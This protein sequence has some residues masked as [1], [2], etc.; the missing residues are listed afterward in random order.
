MSLIRTRTET[1]E[2]Y[3]RAAQ[4]GWTLPCICTENLTTTEA[5]LTAAEDF[6]RDNG[7]STL[8]VIVAMTCRYPHRSQAANYTHTRRWETGLRLFTESVK[9]LAGTGGP[10][11][12]LEVMLHLDH[13]QHDL[14][15]ELLD[16]DLSDYASIMFDAS[17]LPFDENIRSTAAFI[18]RRG[19][20]LLV[21]GACDEIVDATGGAH[22][23][24]TT[25]ANARRFLDE[26]GAD[27]IV[28]NLGTEHRASG[29]ELQYHGEL[30]REIKAV[31]GERIVLHG[32]S[33]V[34]QDQVA[35]LFDD[36]VC[37]VNIWTALERDS[38]PV[39][40]E[41]M[42]RNAGRIAGRAVIDRLI[43]DGL[44]APTVPS[45]SPVSLDRFTTLY[46]QDIVF[47]CMRRLVRG[48]YD[49]WYRL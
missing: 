40:F 9:L 48:Y 26:T 29:R 45:S 47:E 17:T 13:I 12:R 34:P 43:A 7:L 37:K 23:A 3:R 31:A 42:V 16:S 5:I 8:P 28:C 36:G 46:R 1:L 21:E 39:L 27:L 25:P 32:A 41:S 20:E 6:R 18:R 49:L 4:R 10:F 38:S 30:S 44:L 14:D 11:E 15:R 33:S 22:N 35:G 24:L 2:I 19:D